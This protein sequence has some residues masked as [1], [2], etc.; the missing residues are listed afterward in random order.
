MIG[1][2]LCFLRHKWEM[3]HLFDETPDYDQPPGSRSGSSHYR[4]VCKRCGKADLFRG[5]FR[6]SSLPSRPQES[7]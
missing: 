1:R 2:L 3:T 5:P 6:G 7:T 4:G